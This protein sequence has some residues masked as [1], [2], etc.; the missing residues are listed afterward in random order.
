VCGSD[1]AHFL[2]VR[3]SDAKMF[4][5]DPTVD[6]PKGWVVGQTPDG[7]SLLALHRNDFELVRYALP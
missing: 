2:L 4:R 7:R 6:D 1:D 5:F 3:L